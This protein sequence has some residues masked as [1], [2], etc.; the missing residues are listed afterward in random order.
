MTADSAV[1]RVTYPFVRCVAE[2]FD[3]EGI[4]TILSWKPGT[5]YR[6]PPNQYTDCDRYADGVGE[7]IL[8]EVGRYRPGK[9]PER[10]FFTRRFVSPDGV[11]FGKGKL[12]CVIASKF[13]RISTRYSHE[14]IIEDKGHER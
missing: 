12:H 14:Y 11:E 3:G 6:G 5:E 9:Y 10:V 8:T 4:S 1:Y 13:K 7:M 2:V